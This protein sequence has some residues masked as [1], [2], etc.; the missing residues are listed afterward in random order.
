MR[1]LIINNLLELNAG[2]EMCIVKMSEKQRIYGTFR[3][4]GG[5]AGAVLIPLPRF[6]NSR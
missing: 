2:S 5:A 4:M 3:E 6:S 1:V